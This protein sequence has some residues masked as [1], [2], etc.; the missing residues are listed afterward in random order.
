LQKEEEIRKLNQEIGA[1]DAF[2]KIL[3]ERI[4]GMPKEEKL[5]INKVVE[6]AKNN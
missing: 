1:R 3:D 6:Q 5:N 2:L 4:A